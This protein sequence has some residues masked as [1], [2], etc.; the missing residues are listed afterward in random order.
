MNFVKDNQLVVMAWK[1]KLRF[2]QFGS[3][4]F[5]FEVE[6]DG[7]SGFANIEC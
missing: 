1:I 3:I 4:C 2:Q 6:I 5:L 7:W